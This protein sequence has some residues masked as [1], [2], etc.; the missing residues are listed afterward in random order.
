[1]NIRSENTQIFVQQYCFNSIGMLRV[2]QHQELLS[3]H[4]MEHDEYICLPLY[5][6]P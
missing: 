6:I 3:W 4:S 1:M 2:M 5:I